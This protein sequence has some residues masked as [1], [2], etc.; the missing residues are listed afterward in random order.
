M[1]QDDVAM[2]SRWPNTAQDASNMA[3]DDPEMAQDGPMVGP[4]WEDMPKMA[5]RDQDKPMMVENTEL[6]VYLKKRQI[7]EGSGALRHA[8]VGPKSSN[9][10]AKQKPH[11]PR[12]SKSRLG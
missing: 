3:Q 6:A 10:E 5:R 8:Q 4:R 11:W 12:W 7:L 1:A 9:D 2:A